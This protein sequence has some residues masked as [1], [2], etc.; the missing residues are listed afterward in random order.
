LGALEQLEVRATHVVEHDPSTLVADVFDVAQR[1]LDSLGERVLHR[2]LDE[3]LDAGTQAA[4]RLEVS[5]VGL[6]SNVCHDGIREPGDDSVAQEHEID[7]SAT[8]GDANVALAELDRLAAGKI[9]VGVVVAQAAR[10]NG[11]QSGH[12]RKSSY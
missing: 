7:L 2:R 10:S 9:R 12:D 3:L 6:G 8:G 11:C 5:G 4:V 1:V